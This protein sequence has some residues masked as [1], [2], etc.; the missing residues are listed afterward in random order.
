MNIW[1]ALIGLG[2][3]F[4]DIRKRGE[5]V[6]KGG[7]LGMDLGGVREK[8][9]GRQIKIPCILSEIPKELIKTFHFKK[10][11]GKTNLRY[12]KCAENTYF[13]KGL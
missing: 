5:E 8:S 7:K 4:V 3:L 1:A 10:T 6:G 12:Q 11:L 13:F 9:E 2:G